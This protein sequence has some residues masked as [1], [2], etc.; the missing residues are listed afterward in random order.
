MQRPLF[1]LE[2]RGGAGC[3]I[4]RPG[5]PRANPP[6]PE[7]SIRTMRITRLNNVD[8]RDMRI[9]TRHRAEYGDSVNQVLIF[10]TEFEEIQR[11]YP[12]FFRRNS[13][14][15]LQ[16][17][18]LL[19]LDRDENL[20]LEDEGWQARYVP[21]IQQRGPFSIG[22][23]EREEEGELRREPVVNIDLDHP[24]VAAE[25]GLQVF[26]PHGGNT[27]YL[28]HIAKMLRVIHQG[29]E[30]TKPMFAAF[31]E[32]ELIEP[33]NVEIKLSDTEQYNVPNLHTIGEARLA[34]LDGAALERLHRGGYLRAAFNVIASLANVYRLIELKNRK[35]NAPV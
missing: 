23:E 14:G 35:R 26:L 33:V 13:D 20:F 7:W 17:V 4:M 11:D 15:E 2:L 19:G 27:P 8:H 21:A 24:R 9:D 16:P 3:S 18:A 10:P 22:I 1:P 25:G 5:T 34:A 28:D 32:A 6:K 12:I 30:L 29:M 31:E